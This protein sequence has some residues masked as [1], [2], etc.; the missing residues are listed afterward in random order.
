ME[1]D[2]RWRILIVRG[3]NEM[4]SSRAGLSAWLSFL[5]TLLDV[6]ADSAVQSCSAGKW[7]HRVTEQY[8][9]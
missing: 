1:V 7:E 6:S 2:K 3:Q 9:T 8:E 5:F 4:H